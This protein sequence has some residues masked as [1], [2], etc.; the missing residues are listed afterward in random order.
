MKFSIA[1][2]VAVIP[3]AIAFPVELVREEANNDRQLELERIIKGS[4]LSKPTKRRKLRGL[5]EEEEDKEA[6]EAAKQA[7]KEAEQAA[8]IERKKLEELE[9]AAKE[10]AK[11]EAKEAEERAYEYKKKYGKF[12]PTEPPVFNAG[13]IWS[14]V[15]TWKDLGIRNATFAPIDP[16]DAYRPAFALEAA[17]DA[18][19]STSEL[20]ALPNPYDDLF[21]CYSIDMIASVDDILRYSVDNSKT[22]RN[23]R[24]TLWFPVQSSKTLKTVGTYSDA[25][26]LTHDDDECQTNGLFSFGYNPMTEK[27]AHT[28]TVQSSCASTTMS[29]TGGTGH[30]SC[31]SGYTK[32]Y[33][34]PNQ[35]WSRMQINYC[36]G[37][38]GYY[39]DDWS[40]D[41]W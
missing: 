13:G 17:P 27:F 7:A 37:P 34:G 31:A 29:V 11:Q 21:M 1:F 30:F 6:K 2:I 38:C 39:D 32:I 35:M 41:W 14:D 5:Q 22:D 8:K 9:K 12:P 40:D 18:E 25:S 33:D 10:K 3:A 26:T 24:T 4:R 23:G 16:M 15:G 19:A 28:I 36:T 20:P